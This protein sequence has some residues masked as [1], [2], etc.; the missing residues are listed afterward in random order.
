MQLL[1]KTWVYTTLLS[2]W[3]IPVAIAE[4]VPA[5][6]ALGVICR[7]DNVASPAHKHDSAAIG[8]PGVRNRVDRI[9]Q[10]RMGDDMR[11]V[12]SVV[13][14]RQGET[15]RFVIRNEGRIRHEMVLG[16]EHEL[17][18]HY[19]QMMRLPSMKHDAPQM[20]TVEPDQ[21][22]EIVWQFTK[23]GKVSFAC[24]QPGHYSAGMRG[25]LHVEANDFRK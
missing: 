5:D 2:I 19:R 10:V 4:G 8:K 18:A 22:G 13:K 23:A 17:K 14:V 3:T 7:Q 15:I 12:P 11:F 1:N 6:Q 9:I 20:V 24:L 21:T 25:G 16:T